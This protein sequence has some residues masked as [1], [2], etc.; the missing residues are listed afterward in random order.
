M[1]I[2]TQLQDQIMYWKMK[3]NGARDMMLKADGREDKSKYE[4][5]MLMCQYEE[6]CILYTNADHGDEAR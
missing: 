6:G 4:K 2:N 1:T 3:Y 5:L